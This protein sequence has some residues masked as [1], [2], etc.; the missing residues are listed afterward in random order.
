MFH[1]R[2]LPAVAVLGNFSRQYYRATAQN[3]HRRKL[4]MMTFAGVT[5]VSATTGLLWNR[6]HAE[7]APSVKR[8]PRPDCFKDKAEE[9]DEQAVNSQEE[10]VQIEKKKKRR[11]FR[12]RKVMEYENRI[13]A[14]ST[15]DKIFRYFA[16][17]KIINENGDS[18]V[19]MT[20]QD[21]V[22]SITPNEKQPENQGLDQFIVKRYD[23][24]MCCSLRKAVVSLQKLSH[25]R[26]KFADEDSIFYTLGE[27]GL[28][29]F[30]D[31]IF[32]TTVLSTPHRNFEIAFKMFD[33]NGDGEV[34]LEEF[35][36][37][38]SIIRSQTSIGM[39]HR[40]RSTTGNTL[41]SGVSS[42]LTTYFFCADLKGKL[43]IKHF[44]EFQ[45]KL[46]QDVLKLEFDR[47]DPVN[48]RISERQFGS[49]LLAYSGVQSKKLMAM[50]KSIKKQFKNAEGIT[51]AEVESFFTFLKNINDVDTALSFYHM[52]GASI[53]KATMKQVARTVARVEL[54]DHVCDV[55]FALFDSDGNGEL[56][57]REFIS[58]MKQRLMRGLEKPKDTGFTRL[59]R[60]MWKCTQETAWDLPYL[61]K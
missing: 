56:S 41:K 18:E 27:C 7:G 39:R 58:I 13:R 26:E 40:D 52:A 28:I 19:F 4:M 33:L 17:L 50:L 51:F 32:L 22:R 21:F 31:Y 35:E 48:G 15:P 29:S 23:G 57:N 53:D 49:M 14:Y 46:Q 2:M 42:A 37:V 61:T 6:A 25:G 55:V 24:K 16:T 3:R 59:M 43:T 20:P 44:L 36:Q 38:Q 10:D 11:G 45:R 9:G 54:S 8:T 12:D 60:A 1:F 30:S 47:H 5:A 34:D